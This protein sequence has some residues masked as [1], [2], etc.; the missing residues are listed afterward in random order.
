MGV[1]ADGKVNVV[2]GRVPRVR[3]TVVSA[4]GRIT[5]ILS[6]GAYV[7]G[8]SSEATV[9]ARAG[10]R[11]RGAKVGDGSKD[12]SSVVTRTI[13]ALVLEVYVGLSVVT[14]MIGALVCGAYV[15]GV[16]YVFILGANVGS[17]WL[18]RGSVDP[19]RQRGW[20][21]VVIRGR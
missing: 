9:V 14:R 5:G 12:C 10:P 13:G 8:T 16:A 4:E 2:G 19:G 15:D 21:V 6:R 7:V 1:S 11:V 18:Q 3:I 20:S 17:T